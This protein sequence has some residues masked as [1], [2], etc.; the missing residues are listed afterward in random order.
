MHIDQQQ[1]VEEKN[2][3]DQYASPT[4]FAFRTGRITASKFKA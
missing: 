1:N 4:W 3:T 2:S